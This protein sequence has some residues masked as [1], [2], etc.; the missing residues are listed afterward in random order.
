MTA[1]TDLYKIR[2]VPSYAEHDYLKLVR[3][4]FFQIQKNDSEISRNP[5]TTMPSDSRT[6][7]H[8]NSRKCIELSAHTVRIPYRIPLH[9]VLRCE[10]QRLW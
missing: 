8:C 6:L 9:S 7:C 10:W 3:F 1:F 5:T 2:H 4:L